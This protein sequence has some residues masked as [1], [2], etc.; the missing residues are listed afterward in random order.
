MTLSDTETQREQMNN[1]KKRVTIIDVAK[2]A[3]VSTGTVSRTINNSGYV[4]EK[5]RERIEEAIKKLNFVPNAAA[6]SMISKKSSIIGVAVPEINNP[7]LAD[8]VVRIESCLSHQNYSVLLCNTQYKTSKIRSF[9]DDMIMRNVEGVIF[10]ASHITDKDILRKLQT[11]M[12]TVSIGEHVGNSDTILFDDE[13]AAYELTKHLINMGHTKISIIGFNE[14]AEQTM[15]RV[16]GFKKA[17]EENGLEVPPEY[18]VSSEANENSGYMCAKKLLS[19][20]VPPT[21]IIAINDF[22]AVH[23]Y[24][25]ITEEGK[26]V[27]RDVSVVGFDDIMFA[28]LIS[29]ALTT[30]HYDTKGI[31]QMAASMLTEKIAGKTD[32]TREINMSATVI[33]RESAQRADER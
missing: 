20:A 21:A 16:A 10:V 24:A 28:R 8:L 13:R 3:K 18:M 32:V 11:Y 1:E 14:N 25:A 2:Y 30:V 31:A 23:A 6:R 26:K 4:G 9:V 19:A 22:Y 33:L 5:T 27:G 12:N 7:W 29:P 15:I 17:M